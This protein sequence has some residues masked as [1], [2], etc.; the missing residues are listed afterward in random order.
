MQKVTVEDDW[1][2]WDDLYTEAMERYVGEWFAIANG[3]IYHSADADELEAALRSDGFAHGT[4]H[5]TRI[6]HGPPYLVL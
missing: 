6:P 3:K 4:V 5:V 2:L 1:K